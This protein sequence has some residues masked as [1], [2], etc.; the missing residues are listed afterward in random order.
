[1][2]ATAPPGVVA[3]RDLASKIAAVPGV[4]ATSAVDHSYAYVGPDLQD[5]FGITPRTLP[6]ATN[7]RD[8]Y[9]L[10][11]SAQEMMARLRARE[12]GI[13]VS[14]ETISDYSLGIG[15]LLRLR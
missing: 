5:T 4:K 10:R 11:G 2:T 13:L 14:K 1:V 12:D 3:Q 9:F 6:R 7:L 8:S 15:D